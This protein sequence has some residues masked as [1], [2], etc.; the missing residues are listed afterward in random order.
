MLLSAVRATSAPRTI[1]LGKGFER[2]AHGDIAAHC[3]KRRRG[4]GAGKTIARREV[5][6]DRDIGRDS[7][8]TKGPEQPGINADRG[9]LIVIANDLAHASDEIA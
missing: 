7:L 3:I 1:V 5:A 2:V 8:D 4:G 9:K 6:G